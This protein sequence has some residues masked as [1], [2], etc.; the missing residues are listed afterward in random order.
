MTVRIAPA[1]AALLAALGLAAQEPRDSGL[2]EETGRRLIQLDVTASGPREAIA[3]LL[4]ADFEL[5]VGGRAIERFTVDDLC[6]LPGPA[7]DR[8]ATGSA[9]TPRAAVRAPVA[10]RAVAT[11]LFYFDQS[12]LTLGGR[13]QA[14]ALARELI[15]KLIVDGN[16]GIVISA[17]REVRAYGTMT[18]D[19]SALLRAVEEVARDRSQ[20]DPQT[21]FGDEETRIEEVVG[22]L[23]RGELDAARSLAAHYQSQ[24]SWHTDRTLR[25]FSLALGRLAD[26]NPPK[27]ALYFADTMRSNAG[28]HY[29]SFFG[30]HDARPPSPFAAHHSFQRV[31][32]EASSLEIRLY[33]V[34]AQGL[35]ASSSRTTVTDSVRAGNA[36]ASY[37]SQRIRD[38][39]DSLV[40]LAQETGGEAFLNGVPAA[41]IAG[42]IRDD[43]SCLYL[44]SFDPEGLPQNQHLPVSLR[45]GRKKVALQV[46]GVLVIQSDERRRSSRLLAAFATPDSVTSE[47]PLAGSII[48]TGFADGKFTALVQIAVPGAPLSAAVWDLG[49]SLVSRG[50]V[51]EDAAGRVSVT[52]AGVPVV[53]EAQMSF[54]PGPFELISVAHEA[55]ADTVST[56][57]VEGEWPDP[58]AAAATIGPIAVLQPVEAAFSREGQIRSSGSR[59]LGP[60]EVGATDRPT[61]L[62]GIVCRGA[63]HKALRLERE[64]AG[65]SA[66]DFPSLALELEDEPCAL[67]VDQIPART[68]SE[69]AFRYEVRVLTGDAELAA[70]RR[71]FQVAM[72]A[73]AVPAGAAPR[74]AP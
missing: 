3:G 62:V 28:D 4:A 61:A 22:R 64:L 31:I 57:R 9:E 50:R 2:V 40:G 51:R 52:R 20:W 55:T 74:R 33:T 36:S 39:Q 49:M 53:F 30:A 46:K 45:T 1:T 42:K 13:Q 71:E 29:L 70:A 56:T 43:L 24:E 41:K 73:G 37:N 54:G 72:P 10:P 16:R 34:Q 68:M 69:G 15:P 21:V 44:I 60:H 65:D 47:V 58:A 32:E 18:D 5:A 38:A 66:A 6:D 25:L 11:Y 17:G 19:P 8:E 35:V 67:F 14:L 27:A 59:A 63:G 12:Q 7:A 48:P 26:V 23:N